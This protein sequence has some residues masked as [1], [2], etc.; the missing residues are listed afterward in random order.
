MSVPLGKPGSS[1]DE[2]V[3]AR[4]WTVLL[5]AI[6]SNW[7]DL[8]VGV[9]LRITPRYVEASKRIASTYLGLPWKI[10]LSPVQMGHSQ[11]A[12]G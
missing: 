2:A 5:G 3:P 1:Q 12:I 8:F 11:S 10:C 6:A 9:P 4:A 7:G